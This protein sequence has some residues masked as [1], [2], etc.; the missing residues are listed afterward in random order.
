MHRYSKIY[1][2]FVGYFILIRRQKQVN[3]KFLIFCQQLFEAVMKDDRK[4][5]YLLLIHSTAEDVNLRTNDG[6]NLTPLHISCKL[7]NPIITQLILWVSDI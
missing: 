3:H 2:I 1:A 7:G 6:Q 5:C 4:L